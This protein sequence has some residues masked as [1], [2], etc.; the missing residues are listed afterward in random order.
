MIAALQVSMVP[1]RV[2]G[3]VFKG[4]YTHR[5][6]TLAETVMVV[7]TPEGKV[8]R[9]DILSFSEPQD[10]L[11]KERWMDQFEGKKL[12]DVADVGATLEATMPDVVVIDLENP[13]RD[14]LEHFFSL[15]RARA[16]A[17]LRLAS[18]CCWAA[19][20]SAREAFS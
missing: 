5:V 2:G 10:Y 16:S 6:R 13:K 8:D 12:D 3:R 19:R 14:T 15:S 4:A 17:S 11:P 20:Y 1:I 9:I 18:A 7:V